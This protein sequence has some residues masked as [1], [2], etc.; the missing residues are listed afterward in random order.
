MGF[1]ING[2]KEHVNFGFLYQ[3]LIP[4]QHT[5]KLKNVNK[6]INTVK[7]YNLAFIFFNTQDLIS[8]DFIYGC[9][10][11]GFLKKN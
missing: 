3:A 7:R 5:V 8:E 11:S 10:V 6:C 1:Y 9:K 2:C 4:L